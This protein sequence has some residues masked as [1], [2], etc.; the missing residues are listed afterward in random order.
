MSVKVTIHSTGTGNCSLTGKE[1]CDGLTL[2]FDDGTVRE[3]F[4]SWRGFRQLLGL[5]VGQNPPAESRVATPNAHGK[6]AQ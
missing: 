2:S 4:L 3:A 1:N 6:A 5:T